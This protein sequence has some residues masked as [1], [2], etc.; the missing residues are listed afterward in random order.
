MIELPGGSH[1]RTGIPVEI[2]EQCRRCI[3][4][5]RFALRHDELSARIKNIEQAGLSG[6]LTQRWIEHVAKEGEMSTGDAEK[7]V[8]AQEQR[9]RDDLVAQLEKL[10]KERDQQTMFA[11]FVIDHC[12]SGVVRLISATPGIDMEAEACGS[13]KPERVKGPVGAEI[14]RVDREPVAAKVAD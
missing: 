12:Q 4:L 8:S 10:D 5:A 7:F 9:L 14:L 2:P 3:T 13:Q 11:Q 6:E 1:E